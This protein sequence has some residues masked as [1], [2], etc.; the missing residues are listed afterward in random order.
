MHR[1]TQDRGPIIIRTGNLP[2]RYG[3]PH[4]AIVVVIFD[5]PLSFS[6]PE[7]RRLTVRFITLLFTSLHLLPQTTRDGPLA[8][9][10]FSFH[11]G[12]GLA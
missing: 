6:F 9:F 5:L 11:F 3:T 8:Q 7:V 12:V 2:L 1:Q 4:K 10:E